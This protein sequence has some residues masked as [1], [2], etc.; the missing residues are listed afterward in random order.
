ML[1]FRCRWKATTGVVPGSSV[2]HLYTCMPQILKPSFDCVVAASFAL[3]RPPRMGLSTQLQPQ[4]SGALRR[5]GKGWA[6]P[7]PSAGHQSSHPPVCMHDRSRS[8][9]S[10]DTPAGGQAVEGM[11]GG[12]EGGR[13]AALA[14]GDVPLLGSGV[15]RLEANLLAA[16]D[17]CRVTACLTEAERPSSARPALLRS[18]AKPCAPGRPLDA[19]WTRRSP[20]AAGAGGEMKGR[21]ALMSM[22][23]GRL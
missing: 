16:G 14:L 15:P 23:E 4:K 5:G 22:M 7:S 8:P 9:S 18:A 2:A 1:V 12:T 3:R 17:K 20:A 13:G 19:A 21:R 10:R 6:G 11:R